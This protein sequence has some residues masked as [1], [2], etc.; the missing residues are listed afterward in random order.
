MKKTL[1]E[2]I[3]MLEGYMIIPLTLQINNESCHTES[4]GYNI[5]SS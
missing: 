2:F 5:I 1:L 3:S 4:F